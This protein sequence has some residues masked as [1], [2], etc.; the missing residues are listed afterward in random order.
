K[1]TAKNSN[2]QHRSRV[3]FDEIYDRNDTLLDNHDVTETKLRFERLGALTGRYR[4]GSR[5]MARRV[6]CS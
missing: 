2:N 4:L 3:S 1:K 5:A 6:W